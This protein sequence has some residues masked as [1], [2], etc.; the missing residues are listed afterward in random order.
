MRPDAIEEGARWFTQALHDL[1]DARYARA[2]NRHNLA[3]FLCQQAAEKA[4]K[5][6]LYAQGQTLVIGAL[7]ARGSVVIRRRTTPLSEVC[8]SGRRLSTST[9]S[10]LV[11]PTGCPAASRRKLSMRT[12]LTAPLS[13]QRVSSGSLGSAC[14]GA[15]TRARR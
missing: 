3:C 13:W 11:T 5:T 4:L 8:A 1:D 7:A 6:Y 14:Q 9:T 10:R 12:T 15:E 2:G